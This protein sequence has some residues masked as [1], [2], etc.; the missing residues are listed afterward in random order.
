[1][2]RLRTARAAL[3]RGDGV[4]APARPRPPHLAEGAPNLGRVA[5]AARRGAPQPAF[6]NP[7]TTALLQSLGLSYRL[8][9]NRAA[10]VAAAAAAAVEE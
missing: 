8:D 5:S 4:R 6:V 1:M 7:Q 9:E 3:P 2:P 10:A